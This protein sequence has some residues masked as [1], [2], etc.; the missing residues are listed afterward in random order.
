MGKF[1]TAIIGAVMI[2]VGVATGQAWLVKIGVTVTISGLANALL[3][4]SMKARTNASQSLQLGEVARSGMAGEGSTAGSLVDAFNYGGKYGTDWTV[5]VIA[6]ADHRCQALTGLYANDKYAAFVGDGI[7]AGFK[8]QLQVFWRPGTWDQTVPSILTSNCPV[9]GGTPTW[10]ANDRGRGVCYV[11]VAYKADKADAKNPVWAGGTPR[12]EFIL[13]G[14]LCYSARQDSTVG[15]SGAHRWN[16]PAT[17]VWSDNPIDFRQTWQRGFYAGD[18]IDQPEMLLLG[19]GLSAIEAP[20]ANVFAPANV[21][22][23]MVPLKAGGSERRYRLNGTFGGDD[24]YIETEEDIAAAVGGVVVEREGAVEI[25]PGAA[26]PVVW[27]ITDDDLLVGS[28]VKK[29]DFFSQTDDQWVNGVAAKYIEPAQRWKDHSAPIRRNIDDMMADG[30]P[31]ISQPTLPLVTS[32]TQ[33]QRIAEQVRRMGRLPLKRE[34]KLGPRFIGAE[35]GDWLRWTSKRYRRPG[36]DP[37][38]PTPIVF[39]I[40]SDAQDETWQNALTLREISASVYPWTIADEITPGAVAQ[41]AT[42]PDFSEAP[43]G[44]DW[45]L[46]ALPSGVSVTL[47]F[48]GAVEDGVD[49]VVFEYAIGAVSPDPEDDELWT[50]GGIGGSNTTVFD[51]TGKALDARYWG[52]VSYIYGA[53]RSDRLVLGPVEVELADLPPGDPSLLTLVSTTVD[54]ATVSARAPTS[55]NFDH[56]VF[57]AGATATFGSAAA[58]TAE[59]ID[60]PGAV[61]QITESGIVAG[62]RSYWAVAYNEADVPSDPTGPVTTNI[63]AF[64]FSTGSMPSGAT[65]T[66]ASTGTYRNASG[67]LTSAAVNVARFHYRYNGLAWASAGLLIEAAATN[68]VLQSQ[69]I[70]NAS[71]AKS[72]A[73]ASSAVRMVESA[74]ASAAHYVAQ[75]LNFTA[76]Q[77]YCFSV[78]ASEV[79]GSAKR[80]LVLYLNTSAF[81]TTLIAKFDLATGTVTA[82]NG[83]TAG[84]ID[85]GGGKWVCWLVAAATATASAGIRLAM[86]NI[87]TG[88]GSTYTGDGTSAIDVTNAQIEVGTKPTSRIPTT[89][90]AVTRAAD[91]LA[92][93]WFTNRHVPDGA[94]TLRYTFDDATAQDV[95]SIVASGQVTAP[96]NL[97]QSTIKRVEKV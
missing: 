27:E 79:S 73:S 51:A 9:V 97:S 17:R 5:L 78:E 57:F 95:A 94:V 36:D 35:H 32:G 6:L 55:A 30:E 7:V 26:Q 49:G 38:S 89:T 43:D 4:P 63:G 13:K 87:G 74:A 85:I 10:T 41:E 37:L 65:L 86:T 54:S 52:A 59:L 44:A 81:G 39:R 83:G 46:I 11:V 82:T 75:T 15:G 67:V 2:G 88:T 25:I 8:G 72:G 68:I 53:S 60:A 91:A 70:S 56:L 58:I 20:P 21:C 16:D 69:D 71:W 84:V 42:P 48:A 47:R 34:L 12:F 93:D 14:A 24:R 40:E 3:A 90:A 19:R 64:D 61:R 76:G 45:S 1:T 33:A 96:T 23:E 77:T 50:L 92:L 62:P 18:K 22:D 28:T 31:R 66:R 29:T 80:Y